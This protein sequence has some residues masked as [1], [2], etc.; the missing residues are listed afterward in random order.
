MLFLCVVGAVLHDYLFA[1]PIWRQWASIEQARNHI[2]LPLLWSDVLRA[3]AGAALSILGLRWLD[4]TSELEG[5]TIN[6]LRL[7]RYEWISSLTAIVVAVYI[8][9]FALPKNFFK[10]CADLVASRT[11]DGPLPPY[12][13]ISASYILYSPYVLGLWLGMLFPVCLFFIR[14]ILDD[15]RTWRSL[16]DSSGDYP[17]QHDKAALE[18]VWLSWVKRYDVLKLV[19]THYVAVVIFLAVLLLLEIYLFHSSATPLGEGLGGIAML[20]MFFAAL[21]ASALMFD[22]PYAKERART[23]VWLRNFWTRCDDEGLKLLVS[24]KLKQL[25]EYSE[26]DFL[27]AVLKS[28]G[29]TLTLC[30]SILYVSFVNWLPSIGPPF[31]VGE[32]TPIQVRQTQPPAQP[33]RTDPRWISPH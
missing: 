21:V 12:G 11:I 16:G 8:A 31:S 13:D 7:A 26:L 28:R 27:W 2:A 23:E 5:R 10:T 22:T 20:V 24:E 25:E 1:T 30:V 15:R 3:A 6:A 32:K 29:Y 19:A 14:S 9:Y 17:D 33:M 18:K 4:V